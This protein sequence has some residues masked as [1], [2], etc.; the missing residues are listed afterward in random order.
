M[1][2]Q[3]DEQS[4]RG[5]D[6]TLFARVRRRSLGTRASRP[7][8]VRVRRRPRLLKTP[9]EKKYAPHRNYW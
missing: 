4:K 2:T 7:R 3:I 6:N 9:A 1:Q 8:S 5:H